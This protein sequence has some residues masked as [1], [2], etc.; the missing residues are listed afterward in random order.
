M[1]LPLG[2]WGNAVAAGVVGDVD[3]GAVLAA[4]DVASERCRAA[5]FDRRHDAQLAEAQ[6]AGLTRAI[7]WT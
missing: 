3:V 7:G 6:V 1:R 5:G 2:I 4:R